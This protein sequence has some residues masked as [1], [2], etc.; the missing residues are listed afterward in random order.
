MCPM[1]DLLAAKW[2]VTV[3]Q[4]A[5]VESIQWEVGEETA[6]RRI[7]GEPEAVLRARSNG[8]PHTTS[9]ASHFVRM[10]SQNCGFVA[11][12]WHNAM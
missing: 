7:T 2:G 5:G 1:A 4:G 8:M 11:R 3:T 6:K 12:S 10:V 9:P